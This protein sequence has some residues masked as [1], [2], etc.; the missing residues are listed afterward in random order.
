M[1][2]SILMCAEE[3]AFCLKNAFEK[4]FFANLETLERPNH[5]TGHWVI[6]EGN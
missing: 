6:L 4:Y 5:W 3:V 1:E 2:V